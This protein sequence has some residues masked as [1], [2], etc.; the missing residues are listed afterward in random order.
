MD[1][2]AELGEI[3]LLLGM[4]PRFNFVDLIQNFHRMDAGLL[5]SYIERHA[6]G[7]HLLSAPYHPDR[8]EAVSEEQ[9]RKI[10]QYLKG[11]YDYVVIDTSKSFSPATLAA[12]E[13]ADQ[14]YLVANVD[15]PSLRN[16]QRALPLLKRVVG[17]GADAIRLVV[18]RYS[19]ADEISLK[20][21]QRTIGLDA[22]WTLANDYEAVMRSINA[23]KPIVLNGASSAYSRDLRAM[24]AD[25][26]GI[27][28][29]KKGAAAS[30][31][32]FT[33]QFR[34]FRRGKGSEGKG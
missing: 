31:A 3:S 28:P 21:V 5:A 24:A 4:Q 33:G 10:L 8:A 11:Q 6:S 19:E 32:K 17:R 2:D 7:V 18:N 25:I 1:L 26:A 16:I 14:V 34:V 9:I 20:D 13:Q 30:F 15:L 12:F 23:G 29:D 22:Y 27:Q